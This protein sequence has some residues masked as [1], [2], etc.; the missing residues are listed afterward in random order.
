[1]KKLLFVLFVSLLALNVN[2]QHHILGKWKTIDDKTGKPRSIVEIYE[3]EN[4]LYGKV[5]EIID[6]SKKNVKCEKCEGTDKHKPIVGLVIIRGLKKE[7]DE[8]SNGKILD[9]ESGSFYKCVIKPEG[10]DKLNVRGYMGIS[11]IGRSQ[12]WHRI[13]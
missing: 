9:P 1:M 5:I 7:G 8:Y 6:P 2:A 10:K 12:I 3:V 11:L 13:K 4:K